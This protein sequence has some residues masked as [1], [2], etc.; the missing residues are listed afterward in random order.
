MNEIGPRHNYKRTP[1]E[2][3]KELYQIQFLIYFLRQVAHMQFSSR[4][5]RK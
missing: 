2:E 4:N 1:E 3:E 5:G